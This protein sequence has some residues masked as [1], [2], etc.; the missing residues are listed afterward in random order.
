[1][2]D[3]LSI[4]QHLNRTPNTNKMAGCGFGSNDNDDLGLEDDDV[5]N[6]WFQRC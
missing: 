4:R 3:A 1:M 6:E 2:T 5:D